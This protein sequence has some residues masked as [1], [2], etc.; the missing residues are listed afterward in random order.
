MMDGVE[1]LY[2]LPLPLAKATSHGLGLVGISYPGGRRWIGS[3]YKGGRGKTETVIVN[4]A[5]FKR[6]KG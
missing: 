2:Y 3:T 1:S 6:P 5:N 4:S